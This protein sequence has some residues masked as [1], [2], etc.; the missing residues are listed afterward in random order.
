MSHPWTAQVITPARPQEPPATAGRPAP[1]LRA[2]FTVSSQVR[3][4]ELRVTALGVY[5]MHLNGGV[6]GDHVLAP[7]WT[8]YHHRH[9]YQSF[10]VTTLLRPGTNAWGAYLADGWYRGLL[11]FNGG[12]RDIYGPDTGLLAELRIEYADGS[13]QTVTTG[14]GWRASAGPVIAAGLYE[15]EDFDARRE[16]PGWSE[17][18]FDDTH[19]QP[20]RVVDFDTSVLFPADSPPVRRIECLPPVAVTTSPAGRTLLDFGQNLVGRLR[21]RVRGEAGRTVTLRH[22]EVLEIGELC[23]RPLRGATA[24]D[25]YTLRGDTDGEQWEPR[26]TFHGFRYAEIDNWPGE[27][28]PGDVTAVVLHSDL[29]RTGWF[30][31]SD[32]SLN[33]LH[34]NVVWG[35]RGNF[36]DV[37][38]DCPQRDERLG[39]SG[40]IQVFAPTATFLYDTKDFLRSWL[41]D[42]AADQS[43]DPDGIPP[44]I[45]PT[46][47]L[48]IPVPMPPGNPPMAGWC[49][50]AVIVP[51]V[52]YERYGD[53]EVL[54]TQYP[55]MR[56]W[57]DAVDRIA[58]P[59]HVWGEGFQFGDWLDPTASPDDPGQS[60]TSSQLVAT[61]FF[62]H[63]ARLLSRTAEVLGE[64]DDAER[65]HALAG[66][67]RHAFRA[68]FHTGGGRLVEETQTA[69][70]LALGFDLLHDDAERAEA[71]NR[72]AAL[73]T[74]RGHRIGT[75]FLGTPL[76]C[77]ALTA[78]GHTDTAYRLLLE[79]SCPSWLYQVDM[80]ATTI[81][82]RWDSLLPDGS[83][84]PGEMTSFN[85]YALGAIADWLHRTV[86]GLAPAAPGYRR[87]L[88]RPRPGGGL[89]W[90]K[91]AHETPYGRAEVAWRLH[92]GELTVDVTVPQGTEATIDLPGA[93]PTR[94]GPG[95][96]TFHAPHRTTEEQQ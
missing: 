31:T 80:G 3:R 92:E 78:T 27:L 89:T 16:P 51:W 88:V 28:A 87:L 82:E 43:E 15:G 34:E 69:Y 25:R 41:R 10:D 90:V 38:T 65:Y 14:P 54:R 68:R 72:L 45:S 26:F 74:E 79:R 22:A 81:W 29:H 2:V 8:S 56:S 39:W 48:N 53:T 18:D 85:H 95:T 9:R 77:D 91:A 76:V 96:H 49:D 71:G 5:E 84:N 20:V 44:V 24:T 40:D 52:L 46:I 7:G 21:I 58:G 63:S 66:A 17:P 23:V 11:G 75:G 73:V 57:V 36:L 12:N 94:A 59:G 1:L 4:A 35:M 42:F 61:A 13:L 33:R 86:A 50:A 64:K 6:V 19:W 70:A 30:E 93:E 67:V 37:P 55:S 32:P 47:P 60:M 62:A 83:V